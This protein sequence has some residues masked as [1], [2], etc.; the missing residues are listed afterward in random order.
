[1][2]RD[3]KT[4]RLTC[5]KSSF[6]WVDSR[7]R[8][9]LLTI[10]NSPGREGQRSS[11]A[12][13]SQDPAVAAVSTKVWQGL[14]ETHGKKFFR[15]E[16]ILT[17]YSRIPSERVLFAVIVSCLQVPEIQSRDK[18]FSAFFSEGPLVSCRLSPPISCC[19][20]LGKPRKRCCSRVA[21]PLVGKEERGA[22]GGRWG[23]T[24]LLWRSRAQYA[25]DGV[26]QELRQRCGKVN[27]R[28]VVG[29]GE[30]RWWGC[31]LVQMNKGR[32]S[33]LPLTPSLRNTQRIPP[34][35]GSPVS[36]STFLLYNAIQ[37]PSQEQWDLSV[38]PKGK[39]SD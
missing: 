28:E 19:D 15:R 5:S 10:P 1:M 27:G 8:W 3:G 31:D 35:A 26:G 14:A 18:N 30:A 16:R 21:A 7:K 20:S 4:Q 13:F 29:A 32:T 22:L 33:F 34:S 11:T 17:F 37:R 12:G 39:M 9:L 25:G 38:E 36:P 2:R 6:G 24:V 23:G